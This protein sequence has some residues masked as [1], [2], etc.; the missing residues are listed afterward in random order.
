MESPYC[1]KYDVSVIIV[2]YNQ[3]RSLELSLKA[4]LQQEFKGSYEVIVCDDGSS[5]TLF[6]SFRDYF[7]QAEIPI[8]YVWQQ[9]RSIRAGQSRNNGIK[10]AQG[11]ILLFL[12][13]DMVPTFDLVEKHFKLHTGEKL[14]IAGN[15]LWV[16]ADQVNIEDLSIQ[17][18]LSLFKQVGKEH[19]KVHA[20]QIAWA[21]SDKP[22]RA[23][24][25]CHQSILWSPEVYFDE[26][27]IGYGV[28]DW[29]LAC[30]LC[31][32]HGYTPVYHDELI[33]YQY[34]VPGLVF[35]VYKRNRHDEIV[36]W[37]RNVTY[38]VDKYP[39]L[40]LRDLFDGFQRF[41]LD[42]K[43]NIWKVRKEKLTSYNLDEIVKNVRIWLKENGIY[44]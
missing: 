30:R 20:K 24:I 40:D 31:N 14:I 3:E 4:L 36:K 32:R 17:E 15:R 43:T 2:C 13:G 29:E 35:N 16:F 5:S 26:T 41:E 27:L 38:F 10:L 25:A 12:D 6:N 21:Q 8:R 22:W 42:P 23:C 18:V 1:R 28:D 44:P 37:L 11:K 19:P 7:D 9:D 39:E 34:Q 33:A